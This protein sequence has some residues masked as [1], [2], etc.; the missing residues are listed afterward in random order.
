MTAVDTWED[1]SSV[2]KR[3]K[4][5]ELHA[6]AR[7]GGALT[8]ASAES[9]CALMVTREGLSACGAL[10]SIF[11]GGERGRGADVRAYG[12]LPGVQSGE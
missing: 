11:Q 4:A 5:Q 6:E 9:L 10:H 3:D 12:W 2:S 7:R 8:S 1:L